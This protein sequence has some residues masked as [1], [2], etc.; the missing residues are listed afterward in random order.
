MPTPIEANALRVITV[1]FESDNEN[2]VASDGDSLKSTTQLS[3]RNLNDAVEY[4]SS[5]GLLERNDYMGTAPY[6]FGDVSLNTHGRQF[7]YE[8]KEAKTSTKSQR[9]AKSAKRKGIRVFISH[10]SK[11]VEV[12]KEVIQLLR[13]A[14][15]LKADDIRCTSVDGYR[16]PAGAS[17]DEQ[18]KVEIFESEVFIGL[19]SADS[20]RSHYTLF[21]L[22][23]RWGAK[24]IMT[25]LLIDKKG[26]ELLQGPLRGINALSAYEEAQ[27]LQLVDEVGKELKIKPD[28][29]SAYLSLIKRLIGTLP[30]TSA[31]D[32]AIAVEEERSIVEGADD[33][34][35]ANQIIKEHCTAEWPDDFFM[36]KNCIEQQR[37]AVAELKK[38]KPADISESEFLIIRR[39]AALDWPKDFFM[40]TNQEQQQCKALRSLKD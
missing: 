7:Y 10:S 32:K 12:A 35:D 20:M 14:L 27:L 19:V 9:A 13:T 18:L 11:D 31:K 17:T 39:K 15:G 29:P 5:K 22:G 26:S 36:Q 33:Y 28:N 34:S 25:P 3:P 1:L 30:N 6:D 4:L 37:K 21:E 24:R 2:S 38:G 8:T 40:R 23:A 16:L